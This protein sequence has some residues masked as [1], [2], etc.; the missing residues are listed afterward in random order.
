MNKTMKILFTCVLLFAA[1]LT[2][3]AKPKTT[4]PKVQRA[5]VEIT[6]QGYKPASIKLRKGI[7]A[8]VTFLRKT[9]ATCA[10]EVVI[11]AYG[12]NRDLPLNKAVVVTFTPDK[13]GEFIF[14]CG[15]NMMRGKL[16]VK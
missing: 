7:P 2:V 1:A 3:T 9:D 14:T 5:K 15:M 4:K 12:I 16:I 13:T 11:S 10:K 8:R 6:E